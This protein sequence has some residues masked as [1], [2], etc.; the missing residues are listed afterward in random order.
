MS[1]KPEH[2]TYFREIIRRDILSEV[3][4]YMLENPETE[5]IHINY[6]NGVI[7]SG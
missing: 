4:K 2:T 7:V 5:S 3:S 6:N 1:S